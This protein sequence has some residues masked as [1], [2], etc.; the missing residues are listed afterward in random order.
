MK[1]VPL[2]EGKSFIAKQVPA[3]AIGNGWFYLLQVAT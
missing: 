3:N 1:V 2:A